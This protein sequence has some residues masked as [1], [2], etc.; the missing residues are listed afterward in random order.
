LFKKAIDMRAKQNALFSKFKFAPAVIEEWEKMVTDWDN[1]HDNA[2]PYAEPETGESCRSNPFREINHKY[3]IGTTIAQVNKE[4][5]LEEVEE[6][7]RGVIYL[8]DVSPNA[9]LRVGLELEEQQYVLVPCSYS[10]I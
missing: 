1:D 10:M 7:R 5:A 2:N 4:L 3:N 8:H 9:F 6:A